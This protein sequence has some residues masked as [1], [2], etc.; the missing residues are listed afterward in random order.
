MKYFK[1]I[2]IFLFFVSQS[3]HTANLCE[4]N[5]TFNIGTGIYDITG[6]AAEEGMM[7]YAM[8]NQRTSGILQRLWA[9]AFIIES[10]CNHKRI[11]F[12]NVDLG[13][14]FQG[15]KQAVIKKLKQKYANVYSDDNVLIT[16]IHTH[17]G[18]GG[19][20]TDAL[21]NL[22]TLGFNRDNFEAISN[23]IVA[24]I[25]RAQHN[26]Q[27]GQI[28]IASNELNGLSH[29]RSP[30]SF[31]LDPQAERAQYPNGYDPRMTL[32][33]FD[34][35]QG[36][37]LGLIN[38]FPLHGVSMNNK[39][40]LING[41]NKGY[42]E[43][44]FEKDFDSHYDQ[45]AFVAAFA[46]ANSG[47]VSPNLFDHEG[48]SGLAGRLAIE[49]AGQPQY[50][51]AKQLFDQADTM[52]IGEVDYRHMFVA[53]D[54]VAI[55]PLYTD[56][57]P[58]HT[59]P[60]AIGIS[61]LAGTQD[62]EGFGKQG[63]SCKDLKNAFPNFICKL[64]TTPCQGVK[65]I[66]LQTGLMK[67]H[68]W[69]PRIL[70]LQLFKIGHLIIIAT[71]VEVT[72]IS[73]SRLRNVVARYFPLDQYEIVIS[74]LSNA[75]SGY[76]ATPEEYQL[77]R[78][79]GASTLFGP[80]ELSALEQGFGVLAE[81]LKNNTLL[82]SGPIPPDLSNDQINLQPDVVFDAVPLGK[83]F[84]DIYQNVKAHY[85]PGDMAQAIFWS[86]HPKNN[87]RLQGTF[88]A[89]QKY[90]NQHWQTIRV[91]RDWDTEYFW[92][93]KGIAYSLATLTWYIPKDIE[94][95]LYRFVHYGDSKSLTGKVSSFVGV[96][97]QFNVD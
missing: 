45:N 96:S 28:K 17:S 79:E 23:G 89:V 11:V 60:A 97:S 52:L 31:E 33:R 91:D 84:G 29:N 62:G 46:Q 90:I 85:H 81:S 67:P 41:D 15:I 34:S 19:F 3:I 77:Q 43:Y 18:P 21:Y 14:V 56:G 93:R 1:W 86:A 65:P 42:A 94:P 7:G 73:G 4:K 25:E 12:V 83:H 35:I 26:L 5:T 70:P 88:L 75:Y 82:A 24:A 36:Q 69:T 38:W 92:Q 16:A 32:I 74:A 44:L 59:C 50:E 48:G 72:T 13:M 53:M 71:P 57:K 20:S 55:D 68:P 61:M 27:L 66:V 95:G 64:V 87:F 49:N 6:P 9:R 51:N 80:W 10:P 58:Q 8:L 54:D 39:N 2:L 63:V 40:S 30:Q 22:T 76:L 37:P 47:D 78:Y